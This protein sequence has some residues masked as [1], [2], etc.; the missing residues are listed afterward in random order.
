MSMKRQSDDYQA[1]GPK[2]QK[3]GHPYHHSMRQNYPGSRHDP[4]RQFN[5]SSYDGNQR[6]API[7]Q[8]N[9]AQTTAF[10]DPMQSLKAMLNAVVEQSAETK[11]LLG[12]GYAGAEVLLKAL[13]SLTPNATQSLDLFRPSNQATRPMPAYYA[14]QHLRSYPLP[15]L[16]HV[17]EGPLASAPF[18]HK[19]MPGYVRSAASS[20]LN[21][22]TLEFLGDAYLETIATRIIFAR[23]SHIAAGRQAQIREQ[24]V[25][26][27][28]LL[29]FSKAYSFDK[30]LRVSGADSV[31]DDKKGNKALGKIL[32]DMF[33]AYVAAIILSDP[34]T[35]F[36]R[37]ETWMTEL[38]API[39]LEMYGPESKSALKADYN[40]DAKMALQKRIA[41]Q[42]VKLDY[43]EDKPMRQDKHIGTYFVAL[44][45]TGWG[46]ERVRLGAGEGPNKVEAGN[47]AAMDAMSRSREIVEDAERQFN[48]HKE[49]RR[50]KKEEAEKEEAEK[51]EAEKA[52]GQ[53][54]ENA[55]ETS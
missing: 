20:G 26:N 1:G 15:P 43:V 17:P 48:E 41:N 23:Y 18:I 31:G 54:T 21:Y 10:A 44:Y 52:D 5:N 46:Y 39:L 19:S 24:L 55:K 6:N 30:R 28:T 40:P 37:A 13:T 49:K 29:G 50:I 32:A 16:P 42:T 8:S 3:N 4:P 45:L 11:P 53:K 9:T 7:S 27:E 34:E 33:E 22:E 47:R 12:D 38:W 25:K 14:G 2:R 36:Q 35:G 51:A